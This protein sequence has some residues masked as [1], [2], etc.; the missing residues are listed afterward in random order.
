M[1]EAQLALL[2]L[3]ETVLTRK[4]VLLFY[5]HVYDFPCSGMVI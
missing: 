4:K 5:L 1:D 2:T 3:L